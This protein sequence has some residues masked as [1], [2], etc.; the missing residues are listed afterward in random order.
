MKLVRENISFHRG[1]SPR[2][3]MGVGLGIKNPMPRLNSYIDS[4]L[5][6]PDDLNFADLNEQMD[7]ARR[8][9]MDMVLIKGLLGKYGNSISWEGPDHYGRKTF[10]FKGLK[11][12]KPIEFKLKLNASNDYISYTGYFEL[13]NEEMSGWNGPGYS[14]SVNMLVKKLNK[15]FKE[16]GITF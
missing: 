16:E 2:E 11:D 14:R 4:E 9:L 15:T 1:E 10:L 13:A 8:E 6:D 3:A 5:Q 7:I 12:G